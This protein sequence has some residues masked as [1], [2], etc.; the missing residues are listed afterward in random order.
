MFFGTVNNLILSK[1]RIRTTVLCVITV[2]T[3]DLL[4][5]YVTEANKR[6]RCCPFADIYCTYCAVRTAGD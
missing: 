6:D 3:M 4:V 1:D 2:L 5:L